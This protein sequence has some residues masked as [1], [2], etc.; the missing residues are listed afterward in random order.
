MYVHSSKPPHSHHIWSPATVPL[1]CHL[2]AHCPPR[3]LFIHEARNEGKITVPGARAQ[4]SIPLSGPAEGPAPALHFLS[5]QKKQKAQMSHFLVFLSVVPSALGPSQPL[6][7]LSRL[8][9][10]TCPTPKSPGG[11]SLFV[12]LH[13]HESLITDLNPDTK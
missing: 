6:N 12:L 2:D 13:P 9:H 5:S 10:T 3:H 8:S 7:P 11:L 1:Q 4:A